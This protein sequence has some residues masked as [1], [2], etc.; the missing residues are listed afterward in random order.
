MSQ[1]KR[2]LWKGQKIIETLESSKGIDRVSYYVQRANSRSK[3][4][5]RKANLSD[6]W[7]VHSM[8]GGCSLTV[9][10]EWVLSRL[11]LPSNAL[12]PI[13]NALTSPLGCVTETL[14]SSSDC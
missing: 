2:C 9:Q 12:K 13:L 11:L 4:D 1:F 10:A 8:H 5:S 7:K 14:C 6:K 3:S